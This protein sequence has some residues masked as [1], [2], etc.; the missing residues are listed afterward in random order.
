MEPLLVYYFG[1]CPDSINPGARL[2][3]D[4]FGKKSIIIRF[5]RFCFFNR[6]Y[7]FN[8]PAAGCSA[9]LRA[10]V[11]LRLSERSRPAEICRSAPLEVDPPLSSAAL[12]PARPFPIPASPRSLIDTLA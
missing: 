2:V 11:A 8:I 1:S 5:Q 6:R 12:S 10:P 7:C 9:G 4:S 3:P